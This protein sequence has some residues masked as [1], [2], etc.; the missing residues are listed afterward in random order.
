MTAN[1]PSLDR[2]IEF[3]TQLHNHQGWREHAT[4]LAR[5]SAGF[6]A[7]WFVGAAIFGAV[8]VGAILCTIG[9]FR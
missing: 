3:L 1:R 5:S 2:E 7:F 8:E 6:L 9:R 4:D